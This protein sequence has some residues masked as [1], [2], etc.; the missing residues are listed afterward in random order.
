MH[1]SLRAKIQGK[2][3]S[4][5]W[6]LLAWW[7]GVLVLIQAS[8]VQILGSELRSPCCITEIKN[9]YLKKS[10]TIDPKVGMERGELSLTVVEKV[11][12]NIH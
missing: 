10:P 9:G 3:A 8:Q 2:R 12:Q 4:S 11:N 5:L 7:L 6:P 1:F